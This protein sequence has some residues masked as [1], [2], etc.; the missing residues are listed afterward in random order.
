MPVELF[1]GSDVDTDPEVQ[2]V[3][4]DS[5]AVV[6]RHKA[7]GTLLDDNGK[8]TEAVLNDLGDV[9]YWGLLVDKQYGGA[10]ASFRSFA[11]FLT[12]MA[13]SD[14]T[15][16]GLASVHGCIGAVDPVRTF[17]NAE[18]KAEYLP[19]LANGERLSAF[20]LTEPGAGSDLTALKSGRCSR[21]RRLRGQRREAVYHE[22]RSR[23]NDW[24]GV[25]DRQEAGG[26]GL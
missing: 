19:K 21:W 4:D 26:T 1:Q 10:G 14:P 9:G 23:T 11:P 16:A 17:G 13:M 5:V 12:R 7:A 6:D 22:C 25:S 18:Q 8:L 24:S 3:M 20:A 2:K 15:I